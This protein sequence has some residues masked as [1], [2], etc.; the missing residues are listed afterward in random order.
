MRIIRCPN[1]NDPLPAGA[2]H[3]T[4]CGR[5]LLLPT[6]KLGTLAHANGDPEASIDRPAALKV[7]RFFAMEADE[8]TVRLRPRQENLPTQPVAGQGSRSFLALDDVDGLYASP[9]YNGV[10]TQEGEDSLEDTIED[11][12]HSRTNWQRVVTSRSPGGNGH[13]A[14]ETLPELPAPPLFKYV[15][16]RRPFPLSRRRLPTFWICIFLLSVAAIA[17]LSGFVVVALGR[18][19]FMPP[20]PSHSGLTLQVTPASVALGAM[21]TLH[22]SHFSP[23]GRVGLSYNASVPIVDTAGKSVIAADKQGNFT[24]TVIVEPEWQ[25]GPH[26]IHAE[27]ALLHKIASF[28]LTV[29]GESPSLRPAHLQ[30]STNTV[31]LGSGDQATNSMQPVTLTNLGGG[32]VAWQTSVTQPWLEL[33]PNSGIFAGNQDAKIVVAA[34]RA[35]LKAGSYAASII[36]VSD[37]GRLTLLVK[38]KV[39]PLQPG[40]E[41]VLQL[42]PAVLSFSTIDGGA[43]PPAQVITVSNP[44]VQPLQ[45]S[46]TSVTSDQSSWLSVSPQAGNVAKG[47]SE[48]VTIGVDTSML[49]PGVYSGLVTFASSGTGTVKDSPQSIYVSLT[50]T[51]Q[52]LL[53]VSP[54]GLTFANAYLQ[55]APAA[56]V[57]NVGIA[58]ACS[59]QMHWSAKTTTNKG[60]S[61]L[62]IDGNTSASGVTPAYPSVGV[63]V[64]GL[65]PGTYTG[66]IIFSAAP[67]TQTLPVTLTIGPPAAPSLTATPATLSFDAVVGQPGPDPQTITITNS[68]G[69][70]LTWNA[71]A[72]TSVGGSWLAVKPVTGA[73]ASQDSTPVTV[74]A[75]L[76]SSLVPGTYNGTVTITGSDG[77]GHPALGSPQQIPV[78]FKV[79][80]ACAIS[81]SPAA[82]AFSGV[83]G[84]T[85]PAAQGVTISATGACKHALDWTATVATASGGPWLTTTPASGKVTK[86]DS[87]AT[88]VGIALAGLSA[89]TYTGTVSISAVDD[90]TRQ[91]VGA[92]QNITITLTV[93][94]Q[95]T[96]QPPSSSGETFNAEAGSNP[97]EQTFTVGIIG[98]C[99]GDVTITPTVTL[100]SGSGWLTVSPATAT[101][102]TG[103]S[104]TFTVKVTSATLTAATY[105]GSISLSAVNNGISIVGSPQAVGVTLNVLNPPA[106]AVNPGSLTANVTSGVTDQPVTISNTGEEPLNWTAALASGA[107]SFVSLSAT[108]GTGLAGGSGVN[109]NVSV[110]ATGVASGT[111][112]TNLTI[113]A[114]DPITGNAVSGSPA[115]ISITINVATSSMQVSTNSVTFNATAGSGTTPQSISV[116]NSGGGTLTWTASTPSAASWLTV[117]PASDGDAGGASSTITFTA[118]ASSLSAGT[119][120][121]TVRITPAS[122][123]GTA[124]DVTVT[125]TVT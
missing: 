22:G 32:Q 12:W 112:S 115:V 121:T 114:I 16:P 117:S 79:Q 20:P 86:E 40:H 47:G 39:T 29:T 118:D 120:T 110:D 64:T 24:D 36:F 97:A 90:S 102:A 93:Q 78:S 98:A 2:N 28:M 25:A 41:A 113:S 65:T 48:A 125:L 100:A 116:T 108:S 19:V 111:Y 89:N 53:Q 13:G 85:N 54:G 62:N 123:E 63:R 67:G 61:W 99:V 69:K 46:I 73:L 4:T 14:V 124:V 57:I 71:T 5:P 76:L 35:N 6:D 104:A 72:A 42:S 31:D 23:G 17:G 68:G 8:P 9:A 88:H 50:V 80:A 74:T 96:M 26:A 21:I 33:S 107:P 30:L 1:C 119:Y 18:S 91:P 11:A 83:I 77:S 49:L 95:C 38:M 55:P 106:L 109:I 34:D 45:W 70:T 94:P 58:E 43:D 84:Q 87:A 66:A 105:T 44:G 52:C 92:A 59:S 27:D 15:P 51:P 60:G 3:C 75:K 122:G 56:Q 101:V 10:Y 7:P 82:L 37:A 81:V 103:G